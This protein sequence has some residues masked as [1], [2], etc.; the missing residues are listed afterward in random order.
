M[1][2]FTFFHVCVLVYFYKPISVCLHLWHNLVESGVE[3]ALVDRNLLLLI[4]CKKYN[5]VKS[6]VEVALV[7]RGLLLLNSLLA[8][9]QPDFH[10]RV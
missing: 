5:L 3:V 8:E 10:V 7:D 9:H 1:L 4:L 2:K 6:G